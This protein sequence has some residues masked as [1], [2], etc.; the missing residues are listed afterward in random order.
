M[1][2][3]S[4]S[5]TLASWRRAAGSSR[6]T[7]AGSRTCGGI[8][9]LARSVTSSVVMPSS[10]SPAAQDRRGSC[11]A[12]ASTSRC[13]RCC[14]AARLDAAPAVA[15]AAADTADAFA[16]VEEP[17][18]AWPAAADAALRSTGETS[19]PPADGDDAGEGATGAPETGPVGAD[20][21]D[22]AAK[23]GGRRSEP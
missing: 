1:T 3:P 14:S 2:A 6:V 17:A 20:G 5:T 18:P 15:P 23:T 10:R 12:T 19:V 22:G 8:H 7:W 13:S 4:R 9:P 16:S 11:R 21:T